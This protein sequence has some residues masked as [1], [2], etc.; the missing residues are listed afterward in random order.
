MSNQIV[1]SQ[2]DGDY[3]KSWTSQVV[4][5]KKDNDQVLSNGVDTIVTWDGFVGNNF[6]NHNAG[7]FTCKK[8]GLYN[9]NFTLI[10]E[11]NAVGFRCG[12]IT[13]DGV[14]VQLHRDCKNALSAGSS[15]VNVSM[16]RH[17][18]IGQTFECYGSQGSGGLLD[19]VGANTNVVLHSKLDITSFQTTE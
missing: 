9:I 14:N 4:L 2:K 12:Y 15:S 7:V 17:F 6:F 10:F 16:F 1:R 5:I 8:D 18:S 19:L 3:Y 11:S 13:I